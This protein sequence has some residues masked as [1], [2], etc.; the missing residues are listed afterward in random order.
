[1]ERHIKAQV[2][3]EKPSQTLR[4]MQLESEWRKEEENME[5]LLQ[6]IIAEIFQL[7]YNL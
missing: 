7:L 6:Q 4:Y 5:V 2:T 3:C 1:M